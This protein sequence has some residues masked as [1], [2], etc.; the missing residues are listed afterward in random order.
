MTIEQAAALL[1]SLVGAFDG[2]EL[3]LDPERLEVHVSPTGDWDAAVMRV[4]EAVEAWLLAEGVD[5]TR[6]HL[7]ERSDNAPDPDAVIERGPR[8]ASA[9]LGPSGSVGRSRC[10][11][12]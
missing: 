8:T 5:S 7:N 10:A 6:I 2:A 1:R 3:S 12:R 4:L 11:C 9:R